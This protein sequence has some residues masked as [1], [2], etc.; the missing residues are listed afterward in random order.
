MGVNLRITIKQMTATNASSKEKEG[1]K[2][3]EGNL[4]SQELY[5]CSNLVKS[6]VY[7]GTIW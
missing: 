3:R 4:R 5:F 7:I 2:E 1:G 6:D